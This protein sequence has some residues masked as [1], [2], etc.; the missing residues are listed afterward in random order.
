MKADLSTSKLNC[1]QSVS[2]KKIGKNFA[3]ILGML[4]TTNALASEVCTGGNHQGSARGNSDS[5]NYSDLIN[6]GTVFGSSDRLQ[7]SRNI[8]SN[9]YSPGADIYL[10]PTDELTTTIISS[11]RVRRSAISSPYSYN[12]GLMPP[13]YMLEGSVINYNMCVK[14]IEPNNVIINNW[15]LSANFYK[16][17]YRDEYE[18]WAHYFTEELIYNTPESRDGLNKHP[19]NDFRVASVIWANYSDGNGNPDGKLHCS[20]FLRELGAGSGEYFEVDSNGLYTVSAFNPGT[21][22][23]YNYDYH[24]NAVVYD[25]AL[26][27]KQSPA[28]TVHV[29]DNC[30]VDMQRLNVDS[31]TQYT[32]LAKILP[33]PA[34]ADVVTG[35]FC[36]SR[37]N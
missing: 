29:N 8:N 4:F 22:I 37:I 33:D 11:P 21:Y 27:A 17:V 31:K 19:F 34:T 2:R 16:N 20:N 3:F 10:V 9:D 15:Y 7:V 14:V 12:N 18:N 26:I 23:E 6:L 1:C 35:T 24:Y 13:V 32:I 25:P 28:C 30:N 5:A 36:K